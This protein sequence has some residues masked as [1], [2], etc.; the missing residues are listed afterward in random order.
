MI[1]SLFTLEF[2][3]ISYDSYLFSLT[4]LYIF[5]AVS[6]LQHVFSCPLQPLSLDIALPIVKSTNKL[7]H[8]WVQH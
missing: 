8:H 5:V 4:L 7:T 1:L 2:P 6:H 3:L